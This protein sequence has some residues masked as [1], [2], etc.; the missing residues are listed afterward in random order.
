MKDYLAEV[1]RGD[2]QTTLDHLSG[3]LEYEC[4]S[5]N[6]LAM[7]VGSAR[8]YQEDVV[9]DFVLLVDSLQ[10]GFAQLGVVDTDLN[11]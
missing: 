9:A 11:S 10:Q 4:I 5:W 6:D 3:D 7:D 1:R 2:G 8:R